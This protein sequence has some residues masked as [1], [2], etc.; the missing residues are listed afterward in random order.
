M[1]PGFNAYSGCKGSSW[2]YTSKECQIF[3]EGEAGEEVRATVFMRRDSPED[4]TSGGSGSQGAS[5]CTATEHALHDCEESEREL[6]E[7]LEACRA[8]KRECEDENEECEDKLAHERV[9]CRLAERKAL[10][11][12]PAIH[13]T[14]I[15][16]GGKN[17]KAWCNHQ[18]P[19]TFYKQ[20]DL[21]FDACIAQCSTEA[22]CKGI[23]YFV[24]AGARCKFYETSDASMGPVSTT[25]LV[26]L[27]K[28]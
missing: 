11:K 10:P 6:T 23:R 28:L 19:G 1:R 16:S 3:G 27:H 18:H 4:D 21:S 2:L 13:G 26:S 17:Y 25:M 14:V 7:E 8:G 5:D 12:C 20:N 9:S 15:S 22:R 24:A